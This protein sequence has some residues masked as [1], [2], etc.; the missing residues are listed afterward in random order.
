MTC[1]DH[2]AMPAMIQVQPLKLKIG[3]KNATQDDHI[4]P[5]HSVHINYM[6]SQHSL[7]KLIL[8]KASKKYYLSEED[9]RR[10]PK[11]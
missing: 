1:E 11:Y 5:S 4:I 7:K 9:N 8:K 6:N 2:Q 3:V 10:D